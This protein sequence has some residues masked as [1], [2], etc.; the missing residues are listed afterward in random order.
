MREIVDRDGEGII[1]ELNNYAWNDKGTVP[2][3]KFNHYI[4]AIR[5]AMMYLIQGK[6]SGVYNIR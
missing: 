6:S 4:D 5:Y 3:D 2:V 1:K